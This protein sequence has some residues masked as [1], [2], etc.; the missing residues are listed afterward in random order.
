MLVLETGS[1]IAQADL[2]LPMQLQMTLILCL[3]HG[4]AEVIDLGPCACQASPPPRAPP[5]SSSFLYQKQGGAVWVVPSEVRCLLAL[6]GVS[7]APLG[8]G[9]KLSCD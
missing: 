4:S 1:C 2:E 8:P 5:L 9:G 7:N 3:Y 6:H